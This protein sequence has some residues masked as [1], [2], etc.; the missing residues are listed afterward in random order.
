MNPHRQM[1]PSTLSSERSIFSA[2]S[3]LVSTLV[4]PRESALRRATATMSGAKSVSIA[5]VGADLLRRKK[6]VVSRASGQVEDR[7][8][9]ARLDVLY[10]PLGD[11]AGRPPHVVAIALPAG[12]H[13]IPDGSAFLACF[14]D[15]G[16][17]IGKGAGFGKGVPRG[18]GIAGHPRKA[19]DYRNVVSCL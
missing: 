13:L 11:V 14:V 15:H 2:S 5:S 8:A 19:F 1:I 17:T 4:N 12:R 10:Q 6:T 18:Y 9:R 3:T 16:Q 7:V